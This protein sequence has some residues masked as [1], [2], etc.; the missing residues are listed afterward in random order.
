MANRHA[1]DGGPAVMVMAAPLE[2][3]YFVTFAVTWT[4]T[5]LW[6]AIAV[7]LRGASSGQRHTRICL[8][9]FRRG[10]HRVA[11]CWIERHIV[12]SLGY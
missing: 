12:T 5:R 3:C 9:D 2:F 6:Q 7:K 1:A 8:I 4:L 11:I 10:R